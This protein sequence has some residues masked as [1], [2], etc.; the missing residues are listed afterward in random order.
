MKTLKRQLIALLLLFALLLSGCG[1]APESGPAETG[2]PEEDEGLVTV[3]ERPE[4]SPDF[5]RAESVAMANFLCAN[6]A[7]LEGEYLYTLEYDEQLRSVLGRY[8][9]VD[10]TLRE[11]TV[12]A[13][14]CVAE[15]LTEAD[16]AL[17]YLNRGS[18]ERLNADGAKPLSSLTD[19]IHLHT[20][21]CP[22]EA[23]FERTNEALRRAG[24]LLE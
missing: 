23:A 15:Y 12:L 24:F 21:L 16:G 8:R 3:I 22:D 14:D 17:F 2:E 1:S 4:L 5:S 6:R 20:L 13:E 19:G 11:F 18:L 7:L 10:N 9:V